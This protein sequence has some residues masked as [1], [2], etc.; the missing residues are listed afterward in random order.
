VPRRA[1]VDPAGIYHIGSRGSYGRPLFRNDDEHEL[2]LS[3]YARVAL[4]YRWITL[5]WALVWNH[6]HFLIRLTNGGLSEGM[7]ELHTAFSRRIHVIYE[8]TGQG[9]LVR[10]GFFA[11]Q[12]ADDDDLRGVCRYVDLNPVRANGGERPEDE[13]WCGLRA[14]LGLEHA[15]AFHSPSELLALFGPT[16]KLARANYRRFLQEGLVLDGPVPSPNNMVES[17]A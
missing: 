11:R 15:R 17:A 13:R 12:P 3:L 1:P 2:F 10:H 7:R 16:P 6:H 9:H 5:T 4:K 8:L 14:T